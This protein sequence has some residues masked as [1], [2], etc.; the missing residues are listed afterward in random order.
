MTDQVTTVEQSRRLLELGVS[1]KKA[2]MEWR[3]NRIEYYGYDWILE[4]ACNGGRCI[5]NDN[6]SLQILPAFTVADLILLLPLKIDDYAYYITQEHINHIVTYS[7]IDFEERREVSLIRE[8]G[9]NL[10]DVLY[11]TL[12]QTLK[13]EEND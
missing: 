9:E 10:I 11:R 7:Y 6:T 5:G 3:T 12:C 1:E 2:S 13:H 8:E 4:T